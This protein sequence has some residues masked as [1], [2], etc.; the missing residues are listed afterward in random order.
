MSNM[1]QRHH[2]YGACIAVVDWD[3]WQAFEYRFTIS[4]VTSQNKAALPSLPIRA[5]G[6][7]HQS[8]GRWSAEGVSLPS[9]IKKIDEALR[10]MLEVNV[11]Y[12][13]GFLAGGDHLDRKIVA[14]LSGMVDMPV[15]VKIE[16]LKKRLYDL[17]SRH[18]QPYR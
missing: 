8:G 15:E 5:S 4:E 18:T 2:L 16:R 17:E 12:I 13:S 10:Y 7:L 6:Y 14:S 1:I 11:A 3:R 9:S